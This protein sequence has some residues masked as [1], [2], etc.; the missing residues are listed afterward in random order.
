[1]PVR[2]TLFGETFPLSESER[3]PAEMPTPEGAKLIVKLTDWPP[4]RVKGRA[5]PI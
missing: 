4:D 5:G 3:L 2:G 1:V